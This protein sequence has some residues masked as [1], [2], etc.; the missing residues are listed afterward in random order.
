MQVSAGSPRVLW[1]TEEPPDRS[2]G[3]GTIRQAYLF[4]AL[5]G[6][7][8]VELLLAGSL[9]DDH[10]RSLATAV[11]ELPKGRA[12]MA[13]DAVVRRILE[14]GVTLGSR[15]PLPAYMA[16]PS[17]RRLARA[18]RRGDAP[19]DLVIVE[20]EALAPVISRSRSARWIL[21]FHHVLSGMIAS[22]VALA[23]GRR[24][25]W[26]RERDVGK[27]RRLEAQAVREYDLCITCSPEDAAALA[28][29]EP[30]GQSRIR[31][32]PNGVDLR[33]IH[34]SPLVAEPR[35]LFPGTFHYSPN[36][37]GALWFCSEVWPRVRSAVPDATLILAGR[38]PVSEVRRLARLPG[39]EVHPDVPSMTCYF[40]SARAV[41][42]P[43]RVGTGTRIKALEAMA[44]GRPVIG[45][46]VG[47]A[48]VG[49][50]DGVQARVVDDA[51][52]FAEAVAGVL[53]SD[54]LAGRLGQAGR[55]HVET[56]F[57]W[58][59]I[60]RRFVDTVREVLERPAAAAAAAHA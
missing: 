36:V 23:P 6:A 21:T 1:V 48:G 59:R 15:Y 26:F 58:D 57:G 10:V 20:H 39:V 54:E 14:L 8:A 33:R 47:L 44:A 41:V 60:G 11:T 4:E 53:R 17:R 42:V 31:V 12:V 49:I 51:E 30:A 7:F 37:D 29:T 45:T 24:Q 13:E 43:L 2:L 28:A 9:A 52:A 46:S 5:A 19:Y 35:I 55:R 18:L 34:A 40:E 16:G 38:E 22:E 56:H 25:R 27:A 50:E 3:G 32:V